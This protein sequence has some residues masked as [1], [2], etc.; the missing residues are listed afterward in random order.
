M[1]AADTPTDDQLEHATYAEL[2]ETYLST[3]GLPP[4]AFGRM[5]RHRRAEYE[6]AQARRPRRNGR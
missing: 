1:T 5:M 3:G 2:V 6:A 4:R